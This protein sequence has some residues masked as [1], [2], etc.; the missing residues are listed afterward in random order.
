MFVLPS[1]DINSSSPWSSNT[2]K[3][4]FI[5]YELCIKYDNE[6]KYTVRPNETFRN[7]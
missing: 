2:S 3:T 4:I 7:R 5:Q 6:E 1:L